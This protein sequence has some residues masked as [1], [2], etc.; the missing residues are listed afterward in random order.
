LPASISQFAA[1]ARPPASAQLAIFAA[2]RDC[3]K[4]VIANK[5]TIFPGT[6]ERVRRSQAWLAHRTRKIEGQGTILAMQS[7]AAGQSATIIGSPNAGDQLGAY[8]HEG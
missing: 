3:A 1:I 5:A 4:V 7:S 2:I 8:S 6:R